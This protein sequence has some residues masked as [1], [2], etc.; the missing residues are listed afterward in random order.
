MVWILVPPWRQ[1]GSGG[2][3]E[4]GDMCL[5]DCGKLQVLHVYCR[6]PTR[7]VTALWVLLAF[8]WLVASPTTWCGRRGCPAFVFRGCHIVDCHVRLD[9]R[10]FGCFV[11]IPVGLCAAPFVDSLE[12]GKWLVNVNC[13]SSP[14]LSGRYA[15]TRLRRGRQQLLGGKFGRSPGMDGH[16]DKYFGDPLTG[17]ALLVLCGE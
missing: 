11:R 8:G 7:S 5:F 1:D 10:G 14:C 2:R 3:V 16:G 17:G 9:C 13:R 15:N 6:R 4:C 12:M